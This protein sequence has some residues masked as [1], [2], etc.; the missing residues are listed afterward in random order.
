VVFNFSFSKN[1]YPSKYLKSKFLVASKLHF[2]VIVTE[3]ENRVLTSV[4]KMKV[5]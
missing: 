2:A 5:Q 4:S 1:K 3:Y